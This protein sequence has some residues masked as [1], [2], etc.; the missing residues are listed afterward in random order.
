MV[1]C[2]LH[3]EGSLENQCRIAPSIRGDGSEPKTQFRCSHRAYEWR[4]EAQATRIRI[5]HEEWHQVHERSEQGGRAAVLFGI[6]RVPHQTASTRLSSRY[7]LE[8][9]NYSKVQL[10]AATQM[11]LRCSCHSTGGWWCSESLLTAQAQSKWTFCTPILEFV[12]VLVKATQAECTETY[13]QGRV[14]S[15]SPS[16]QS[17]LPSQVQASHLYCA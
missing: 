15:N 1:E 8:L 11:A 7:F 9:Y 17:T 16:S 2:T 14:T 12:G 10:G 3:A 6:F 4:D 5:Q 13:I